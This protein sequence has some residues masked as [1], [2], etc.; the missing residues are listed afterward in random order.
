MPLKQR[1]ADGENHPCHWNLVE[2]KKFHSNLIIFQSKDFV[3]AYY[4]TLEFKKEKFSCFYT[5]D[6]HYSYGVGNQ[7]RVYTPKDTS[8]PIRALL[9]PYPTPGL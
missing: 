9:R 3:K 1:V 8:M 7:V 6:S 5:K 2:L 4:K